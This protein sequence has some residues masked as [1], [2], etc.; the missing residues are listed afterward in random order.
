MIRS[1]RPP[2]TQETAIQKV[3][4]LE[5][6][7]NTR[8][9][10][11]VARA[12]ALDAQWL[13]QS[14]SLCGR[15]QIHAFLVHKWRREQDW[16]VINELWAFNG[17][18]IAIRLVCEYHDGGGLWYRAY[19]SECCEFEMN[20]LVRRRFATTCEH[21]IKAFE[22]LLRWDPGR[23]PDEHASVDDLGF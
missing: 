11:V 22:R 13:H 14:E 17:H 15:D 6:G 20:G 2:F 3:R 18:R 21:P 23:R 16:R 19:G 5:D 4:S 7:W 8:D 10:T 12:S 1:P 9:P